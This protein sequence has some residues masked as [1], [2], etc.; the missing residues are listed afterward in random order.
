[1]AIVTISRQYGCS[2]EYVGERV[3]KALGYQFVNNEIIQYVSILTSTPAHVVKGFDEDY[4]SNL[5]AILSKYIDLNIFSDIIK[6]DPYIKSSTPEC[7]E[8]PEEESLFDEGIKYNPI[9]DSESFQKMVERVIF[10]LAQKGDVVIIGRGAQCILKDHPNTF[11]VRL[12]A[13][14]E[15]RVKWVQSKLKIDARTAQQKITDIEQRR[16]NFIKHYYGAEIDDPT[17]YHT[18]INMDKFNIEKTAN[19]II[20]IVKSNF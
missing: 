20:N 10:K 14:F 1:M 8:I 5:S 17:L 19:A 15:S 4:H 12:Y 13:P 11:H 7:I 2:G 16:K 3:A 18:L 9:F 6:D